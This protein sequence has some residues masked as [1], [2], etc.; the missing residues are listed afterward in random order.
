MAAAVDVAGAD[1]GGAALDAVDT[2]VEPADA[3]ESAT[4]VDEV[5]AA[6]EAGIVVATVGGAVVVDGEVALTAVASPVPMISAG[7]TAATTPRAGLVTSEPCAATSTPA[8][9]S[10]PVA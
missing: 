2:V 7:R 4:V 3:L 8:P 10:D 9:V 5:A 1:V 6:V